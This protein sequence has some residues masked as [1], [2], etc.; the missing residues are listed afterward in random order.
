MVSIN[1]LAASFFN[2]EKTGAINQVVPDATD[3]KS[4]LAYYG[5]FTGI[6]SGDFV[7]VT[8]YSNG[9]T[10][11]A[12]SGDPFTSGES[13]I[14]LDKTVTQPARLEVEASMIRAK[15]QFASVCLYG[16]G[17]GGAIQ[18]P[19]PINIVAIYQS[20]ADLG[21]AYNATAGTICT[22]VLQTAL[23]GPEAANQVFLSDWVHI[24]G[25][26]DT[27]LNYQNACIKYISPDRK[28]I[29]FGFSDEVALPSLA[30]TYT[31]ALETAKVY[32]YNN[33]AGAYDGFGIRFA[34]TTATSAALV[35]VF[36]GGDVQ[37][38]GTLIG[39]HRVTLGSTAP[40]YL[41]GTFGNVELKA[42][43]RY[44]LEARPGE[45]AFLDKG[46]DN[47]ATSWVARA[48]RTAVK[49]AVQTVL[50][51]RF[52]LYKPVGMSAAVAKIINISKAGTTTATVVHDGTYPF[53]TGQYVTIKGVR[54][55]TN[56]ATIVAP[57]QITVVNS[58]T[59]TMVLGAAVT[60]TSYG[61][62]ICLC[63]G[64][65]DAG[66]VITQAISTA[67][68][69]AATRW[70]TLVGNTTWSGLSVGDY[71]NVY[72][73]AVDGTGVSVGIDGAWEVANVATSTMVL[74]PIFNVFG[75]KVSPEISS[76]S[77]TNCG[78]AVILRTTLR[79]HDL[80]L[81]TFNES[82]VSVDG[83][84]TARIDK[85][86]PVNVLQG[87]ITASEGTPAVA[88]SS[89]IVTAA[90]T[91]ATLIKST[92]ASLYASVFSN[93]TAATIYVK[94]YNKA[95][96]PTVGTDIPLIT[97]PVP[98]GATVQMEFGRLG[99]RFALGLGIAVTA[100]MI[101]TDTTAVTAGAQIFT[102]YQ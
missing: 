58:T 12:L 22:V 13:N 92:G 100:N 8:K 91:N 68:V 50:R 26:V 27:R 95:T 74:K 28:T 86:I 70:L 16:E 52:R 3:S 40:S 64:G 60:A 14:T 67:T 38:S 5:G 71:V 62:A 85:S 80:I 57:A 24:T 97:V 15:H 11:T 35:S 81:E 84:G 44:R 6:T 20:S 2:G 90:T 53:V 89:N 75:K 42:T 72:G 48:A 96:A 66:N 93:T 47:I 54:D 73:A 30:A 55:Q 51:P 41:N 76:L 56:F 29:T 36:G 61:G 87:T 32:F 37:T 1:D 4:L 10:V 9:Q 59:F 78:G 21:A 79:S 83:Q 101:A 88:S 25:L 23:P 34:G 19:D 69:D 77:T 46:V 63:N 39:D 98:A 33:L 102:S 99:C 65:S 49:P 17:P 94:Y 18:V 82:Q 7:T 45:C 31:P 43:T